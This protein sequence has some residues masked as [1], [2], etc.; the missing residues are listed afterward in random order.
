MEEASSSSLLY[1]TI[2]TV[3]PFGHT[4]TMVIMLYMCLTEDVQ[5]HMHVK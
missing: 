3:Y 2:V 5:K 4:V 1:S